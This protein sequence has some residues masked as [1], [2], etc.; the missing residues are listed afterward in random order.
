MLPF[1]VA[2]PIIFFML[3]VTP[4]CL[5]GLSLGTLIIVLSKEVLAIFTLLA[6]GLGGLISTKLSL[7][8]SISLTFHLF[9]RA[10]TPAIL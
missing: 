8:R 3:S 6:S 4:A 9:A 7:F 1:G 10:S 5:W 2:A